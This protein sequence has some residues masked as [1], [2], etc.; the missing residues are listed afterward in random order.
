MIVTLDDELETYGGDDVIRMSPLQE[1]SEDLLTEGL[2][3]QIKNPFAG[4]TNYLE[5]FYEV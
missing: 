1:L 5:Q 3:A 4:T 2:E